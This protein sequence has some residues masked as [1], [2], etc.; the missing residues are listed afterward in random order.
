MR[1]ADRSVE[2]FLKLVQDITQRKKEQSA[3]QELA[4]RLLDAQ[5]SERRRIAMEMHDQ[6]GQQLSALGLKLAALRRPRNGRTILTEQLA[7]LEAIVKRL[8]ADLDQFVGRLRPPSLDD[9][10]LVA[11]LEHYVNRWAAEFDL[12]AEVHANGIDCGDLTSETATALYRIAQE[13]LN[14]VAKR[15]QA[16]KCRSA[17]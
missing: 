17:S 13:A 9:L 4:R 14:N 12:H 2:Y 3:R 1:R 11:A 15:A 6:F 16:Q 7:P 8:D 10:G 5:E